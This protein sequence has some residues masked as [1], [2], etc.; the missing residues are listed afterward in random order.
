MLPRRPI[1]LLVLCLAPAS[2]AFAQALPRVSSLYPPGARAGTTQDVAIRGGG[3]EGARQ[4]LITGGGLTAT[5]NS[6]DARIDAA[7]QRLFNAKCAGCHELRGPATISRTADQWVATVDRMIRQQGAPIDMAE[8]EKIVSYVSAAA[9]AAAGLTARVTVAPDAAPG[10]RELRVVA[11]NGA[12][13]AFPFEVT[14]QPEVLETEPNNALDKAPEVTLPVTISG[15][16]AQSD[17]DCFSF[18][19]KQGERLVFN[20][21]AYRLNEASQAFFYPVLYLH[22]AAGKELARNNGYFGLD[23]LI[24]WTAPAEGK[25]VVTVRDMLYRGSPSSVYRLAAG[26]LPYSTYAFPPGGRRGTTVEATLAGENAAPTQTRVTLEAGRGPGLRVVSTP[27]GPLPFVAGDEPEHLE[28]PGPEPQA[29]TLPV[30]LNGRLDAPQPDRYTFTL[31]REQLGAYTFDLYAARLASPVVGR[32]TLLDSRGRSLATVTGNAAVRDPRL[33]FTF[34][35]AGDY[36]LVVQD[37]A[38]K[39]S[40]AHIYRVSA[41]AAAPDF[42]LAISPDNPNV[43]PGASVYLQVRVLRRVG[44]AGPIEVRLDNLPPGLTA[45][46]A[47]LRSDQNQAFVV[48]TAAPDAKPGAFALTEAV[49][50]TLGGDRPLERPVRAFEVYRINNNP[51]VIYRETL[52]AAVAPSAELSVAL[53]PRELRLS[54]DSGPVEVRARLNRINTN[55]DVPFAIVGLPPGVQ[56]PGSLLFRRGQTDLTFTLRPSNQGVFAPRSGGGP[57]PPD[58]FLLAVVTGRE[59]EG[60]M[61]CSP[62][63]IVHLHAGREP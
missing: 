38:G 42:D 44:I 24:D 28:R 49:A 7:E 12:S 61:L 33:D 52:V 11:A 9:R 27:L 54:A 58:R 60:M 18:K 23:P 57:P 5:L 48:L 37:E 16:L 59:G 43:G 53:E 4:V 25:Y 41:T 1:L 17:Q 3:L 50:R 63:A 36:T 8:R 47:L 34:T 20:L 2:G 29:V 56:S 31:T 55:R 51:Q 35:Q 10:P 26:A 30:S 13:T 21:S 40:P 6:L 46:P 32:L 15:Q 22:D 62:P 39:A 19:A 14:R 45:T